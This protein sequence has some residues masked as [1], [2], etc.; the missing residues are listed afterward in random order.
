[1]R[2]AAGGAAAASRPGQRT[3]CAGSTLHEVGL[4]ML[5]KAAIPHEWQVPVEQLPP[6][7]SSPDG[8]IYHPLPADTGVAAPPADGCRSPLA[9]GSTAGGVCP[10]GKPGEGIKEAARAAAQRQRQM[11]G[12]GRRWRPGV[13]DAIALPGFWEV[14]E[15]KNHC[16]FKVPP[17]LLPATACFT[18]EACGPVDRPGGNDRRLTQTGDSGAVHPSSPNVCVAQ[19]LSMAYRIHLN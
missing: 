10:G 14:V 2:Q 9:A 15:V 7:G 18:H 4:C 5:D 17:L 3:A 6:I 19:S 16:P 12:G 8:L 1:M 13:A 11:L